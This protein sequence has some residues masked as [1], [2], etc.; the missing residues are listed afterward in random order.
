MSFCSLNLK[1]SLDCFFFRLQ[2]CIHFLSYLFW[3]IQ[4][5]AILHEENLIVI[6]SLTDQNYFS[7]VCIFLSQIVTTSK[8]FHCESKIASSLYLK[9]GM[10][11]SLKHLRWWYICRFGRRT[12]S[13]NS[14]KWILNQI[15][16][17]KKSRL[18][19]NHTLQ[20]G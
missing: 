17:N 16:E 20:S 13:D 1:Q 18:T 19:S 5:Q 2:N 3:F 4:V 8:I 7:V 6:T 12:W 15:Q 14:S 10:R 9:I 11:F